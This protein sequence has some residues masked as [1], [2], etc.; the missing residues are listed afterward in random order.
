MEQ[1]NSHRTDFREI[2]SLVFL[3][4]YVDVFQFW[5]KYEKNC[6]LYMKTYLHF[7]YY[8]TVIGLPNWDRLFSMRYEMRP[9]KML[10]I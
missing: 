3:L 1:H 2:Q 5:F 10:R 4:K 7:W 6:T 8:F 9:K